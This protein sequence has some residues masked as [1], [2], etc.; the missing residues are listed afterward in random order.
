MQTSTPVSASLMLRAL[1][2]YR[3]FVWGMVARELRARYVSS[4]L[5]GLWAVL[6]PLAMIAI[7]TI[8]FSSVMRARLPGLDDALAY[9]FYLCAGLFPWLYFSEVLQRCQTV[10]LEHANLLKKMSFPRIS[11]PVILLLSSTINFT[12]TFGLFVVLLLAAGRF[13][14]WPLV[15]FVPLLA[16]QQAFALGL[17]ILLGTLNVFYRD[18]AQFVGVVLQF[19]FWLTPIVYVVEILPE[20]ARRALAL[21]PLYGPIRSYQQIVLQGAWPDWS[22]IAF[23]AIAAA[24]SLALGFFAF[25]KLSGEMIDEI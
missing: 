25:Q 9:T 17:G 15:A 13:P 20:T 12:I 5:G 23:T 14:G 1:W 21:N 24:V 3:G 19:W 2:H 6:N 18:V 8:I 10:F 11:L 16:V 4:L 22:A 7:Y